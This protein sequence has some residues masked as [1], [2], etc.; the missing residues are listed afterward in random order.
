MIIGIGTPR[1]QSNMPLPM[2]ASVCLLRDNRSGCFQFL[3]APKQARRGKKWT[4]PSHS[5]GVPS[6][7]PDASVRVV[8]SEPFG[9]A[10]MPGGVSPCGLAAGAPPLDLVFIGPVCPCGCITLPLGL[11]VVD[12][13]VG[14]DWEKAVVE[15]DNINAAVRTMILLGMVH[16]Q[17]AYSKREQTIAFR[18]SDTPSHIRLR[19]IVCS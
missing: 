17:G 10:C 7:I 9:A 2:V 12:W 6:G 8:L 14:F 18:R 16:L 4:V 1:S 13:S 3:I 15:A 19:I 11:S 5:F